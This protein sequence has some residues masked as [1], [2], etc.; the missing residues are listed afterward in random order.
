MGKVSVFML[1]ILNNVEACFNVVGGGLNANKQL[2]VG[3]GVA[4]SWRGAPFTFAVCLSMK[5]IP[6]SEVLEDKTNFPIYQMYDNENWNVH[7]KK[8]HAG[9]S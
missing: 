4:V 5:V 1:L 7:Y 9:W 8:F 2:N 3:V 6:S